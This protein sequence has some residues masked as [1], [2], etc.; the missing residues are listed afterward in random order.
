MNSLFS[1]KDPQPQNQIFKAQD[2][3][4]AILDHYRKQG[5]FGVQNSGE[6]DV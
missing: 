5:G 6:N 4:K 3:E 1:S 2:F